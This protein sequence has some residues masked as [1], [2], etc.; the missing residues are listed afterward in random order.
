MFPVPTA[1]LLSFL[2]A[3]VKRGS[4]EASGR[5]SPSLAKGECSVYAVKRSA[6]HA[7]CL[8]SWNRLTCETPRGR[9]REGGG[10]EDRRRTVN[11]PSGWETPKSKISRKRKSNRA[12]ETSERGRRRAT[13][14]GPET[15]SRN[16]TRADSNG[17][18]MRGEWKGG[19]PQRFGRRRKKAWPQGVG[20]L[21]RSSTEY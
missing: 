2:R 16:K 21:L 4:G 18:E 20:S 5:M 1:E 9:E 6:T 17:D 13:G 15:K 14:K 8:F 7:A 11:S 12:P 10:R 19:Q 3:L